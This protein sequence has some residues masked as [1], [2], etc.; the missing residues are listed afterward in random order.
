MAEQQKWW[1]RALEEILPLLVVGILAALIYYWAIDH[2]VDSI[3]R[4]FLIG[5]MI[6]GGT[7]LVPIL[8]NGLR[9][10]LG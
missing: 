7:A 10:R 2:V 6:G 9:R 1:S 4:S 3:L 5:L 8:R